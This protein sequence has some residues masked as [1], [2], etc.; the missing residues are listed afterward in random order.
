M[1][2]LSMLVI[3]SIIVNA[4]LYVKK[5][6]AAIYS[7]K[8]TKESISTDTSAVIQKSSLNRNIVYKIQNEKGRVN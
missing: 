2:I 8:A 7:L 3:D 1:L 6:I 4:N 5:N